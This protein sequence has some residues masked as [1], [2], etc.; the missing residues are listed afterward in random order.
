MSFAASLPS[1]RLSP[2]SFLGVAFYALFYPQPY[3]NEALRNV[4][5]AVVDRDGTQGSRDFARRVDATPDVAVIEVLPDLASA[6]REVFA[7]RIDGILVIPQ[8]FERELL[9]WSAVAGG[10]LCR[11]QLF[12]DLS[13]RR[14]RRRRCGAHD[15]RGSRDRPPD[16]PRRRSGDRRRRDGPVAPDGGPCCSIPKAA[17]R[18]TYCRPHSC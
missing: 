8:Y 9:A 1:S 16:R 18:P 5:I 6:E 10:A 3:L 17:M 4:P 13:A 15:R 7:R 2:C 11:R 14:G 12:P